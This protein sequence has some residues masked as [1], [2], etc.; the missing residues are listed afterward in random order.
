MRQL[1]RETE[2]LEMIITYIRLLSDGLDCD[3]MS[4]CGPGPE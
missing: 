3:N 4:D 2:M 1:D